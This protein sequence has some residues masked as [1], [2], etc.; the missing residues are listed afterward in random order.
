MSKVKEYRRGLDECLKT[1]NIIHDVAPNRESSFNIG[2]QG[3]TVFVKGLTRKEVHSLSKAFKA[4]I[5]FKAGCD[6]KKQV[7][8]Q[9]GSLELV[10]ST[11]IP[12]P[13][14]LE[15]MR[16]KKPKNRILR[17]LENIR[18][19]LVKTNYRATLHFSLSR[20]EFI[21]VN[22]SQFREPT[23]RE[24]ALALKLFGHNFDFAVNCCNCG[25]PVTCEPVGT[26]CVYG[27]DDCQVGGCAFT[28]SCVNCCPNSVLHSH[29]E[30]EYPSGICATYTCVPAGGNCGCLRTGKCSGTTPFTCSPSTAYAACQC[31]CD[32]GYAWNGSA[33]V[34]VVSAVLMRDMKGVGL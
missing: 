8:A 5:Y 26:S 9:I 19:L 2:T 18:F 13:S 29:L 12:C 11:D 23:K 31:V 27:F 22:R 21:W 3:K 33:C 24:K 7:H 17:T 20:K 6:G 10:G 16:R 1:I 28:P 4:T 15:K 34:A 32:D 14:C 30:Q 25:G